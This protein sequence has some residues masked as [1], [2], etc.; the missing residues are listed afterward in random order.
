MPVERIGVNTTEVV[1]LRDN[2]ELRFG[3]GAQAM[4]WDVG[5]VYVR[6]DGTDLDM[7]PTTNNTVMK[8][9]TGTYS[10]DVWLY[11]S[12]STRY[13]WWDA[14][15]SI[16]YASGGAGITWQ[17]SSPIRI[18]DSND[19][20]LQ[21]DSNALV[22]APAADDSVFYI[23]SAGATQLSWDVS[24]RGSTSA[25]GLVWDASADLL[26]IDSG[27]F[28]VNDNDRIVYGDGNDVLSYWDAAQMVL[29][30]ALDDTKLLLGVSAGTQLSF[31][32]VILG[33]TSAGGLTWDASADVLIADS[34][35]VRINDND[36]LR[37][38]D[39]SDLTVRWNGAQIVFAPA[40][41]DTRIEFGTS[42]GTGTIPDVRFWGNTSDGYVEWDASASR[43][44]FYSGGCNPALKTWSVSGGAIAITYGT[45]GSTGYIPIYTTAA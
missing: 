6:W 31:D 40:A 32:V 35:G 45:T 8:I 3:D 18:G 28:R 20:V 5:D 16:L 41:D 19:A 13:L 29:T 39:D 36:T 38:G 30:P 10:M 17:D 4:D 44:N 14:S 37:L 9:G 26:S 24:V 43:F 21:W 1:K 11:G 2:A 42:A 15:A 23:G 7:V 12:T 22:L 27:G 34:A 25:G 33:S